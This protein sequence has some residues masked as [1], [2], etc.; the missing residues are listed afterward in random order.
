MKKIICAALGVILLGASMT[1]CNDEE[2]HQMMNTSMDKNA[3]ATQDEMPYGATIY[4]LLPRNDS[5]IKYGIEFDK[6]YFGGDGEEAD[7][8]EIYLIHDYIAALNENNHEKIKSLY[9]PGYLE[10]MCAM[11]G[12]LNAEQYLNSMNGALTEA[13]GEDFEIDYINVSDCLTEEDEKGVSYF[14]QAESVLYTID[15]SLEEKITSKKA[16]EIGGYTSYSTP[17]GKYVFV[18]HAEP[19]TLLVYEID[20]KIYLL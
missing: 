14:I 11:G 3:N 4:Q 6:R 16:V 8:R 17:E 12:Y 10:Y 15:D 13:L 7:L 2:K 5:N 19:L 9:Y 20:G 1:S 18:N